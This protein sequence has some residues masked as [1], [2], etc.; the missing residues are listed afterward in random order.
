[1]V[2][3]FGKNGQLCNRLFNISAFLA[4]GI[5]HNYGIVCAGF[6]D[7]YDDFEN[8]NNTVSKY[9][10]KFTTSADKLKNR[11]LHFSSRVVFKASVI[12][13]RLKLS[14]YYQSGDINNSTFINQTKGQ[15]LFV[16]GW[17]YWDVNNFVKHS[18]RLREVFKPRREYFEKVEEFIGSIPESFTRLVAVHIRLGDYK[19][20]MNGR[21]YYSLE[22]YKKQIQALNHQLVAKGENPMF[23]VC[24]NEKIASDWGMD[25]SYK[26]SNLDAMSDLLL[27]SKCDY[28]FGPPST[29]SMW[30]SFYGKVPSTVLLE[31]DEVLSIED[32]SPI[33]APSTYA[34]GR[35]LKD[36]FEKY[37]K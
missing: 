22:V 13:R 16:K 1:M 28:I 23:I 10:F 2:V 6:E 37:S 25:F 7:Y 9:G 36:I 17:P 32:F 27:L 4:N 18:D 14:G 11:L 31:H 8:I 19:E 21:F 5:E 3:L 34:N 12:T 29:F 30:A 33:I 24:S 20:Y 26:V 15:L 35:L